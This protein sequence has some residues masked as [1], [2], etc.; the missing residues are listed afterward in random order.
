[1]Y[2][3]FG[4]P[5]LE[6]M[7]AGVPVVCSHATAIPEVAGDAAVYFDP[8]DV[9][10]MASKMALVS[11]DDRLRDD[12]AARGRARAASFSWERAA[13][14]TLAVYGRVLGPACVAA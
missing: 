4:L 11:G 8:R 12:L 7:A 5:V 9:E 3:G 14:E 6:A 10:D 13:R 1:L 2:E